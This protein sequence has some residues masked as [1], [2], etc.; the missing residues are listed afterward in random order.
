MV[1]LSLLEQRYSDLLYY[2]VPHLTANQTTGSPG[3]SLGTGVVNEMQA[4]MSS[5]TA[6][7]GQQDLPENSRGVY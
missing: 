7:V 1:V 3:S 2:L 6:C 5:Y 4:I